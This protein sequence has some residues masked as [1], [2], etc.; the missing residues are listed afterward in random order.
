MSRDSDPEIDAHLRNVPLPSGMLDALRMIPL[1]EERCEEDEAIDQAL[2]GMPIPAGFLE[3]L[4]EIPHADRLDSDVADLPVPASLTKKLKRIPIESQLARKHLRWQLQAVAALLFVAFTTTLWTTVGAMVTAR[5]PVTAEAD[6][7]LVFV[8][9]GPL[10]MQV[11][12]TPVFQLADSNNLESELAGDT[13]T[14]FSADRALRES[15]LAVAEPAELAEFE[16]SS[17]IF[18]QVSQLFANRARVWDDVSLLRQGVLG[19]A[20]YIDD[21]LAEV[22]LP[23]WPVSRGIEPPIA[24]GYDRSFFLRNRVFPPIPPRASDELRTLEPPL[25]FAAERAW[26][27]SQDLKAARLVRPSQI[28]VEDF[29][30]A[31]DYRFPVPQAGLALRT[32]A[33]PSIASLTDRA[34]SPGPR[35]SLLLLGIQGANIPK[36]APSRHMI[37]AVDVSSSMHRQGRMQQVRSALDKFTSQMRDGDQLSIVA[38]RDVSEV[39]VERATASEAQSAV[40]MLDLPV[41]V[42][43]TNLASGLQ[44]SL[45][46]AMQAPG[47]ATATP[48]SA[49]SVVVITDGTPEW[50]HATV[51]QLH[52][53]AADAAQQ[54]IEMHVALVG[55]NARA[56]LAAERDSLGTLA[57]DKLSSLLAGEV[58]A[59]DSSRN[60]YALLTDTLAGGSAVLAS[61]ARLRIDFNPQVVSAYRLL[62]HGA[63]ALADVRPAEVS[64]EIR[65]GETAVVL[66]ELWLA[67]DS[68]QSSS[69]DVATAHLSWLHPATGQA[70]EVRQ[71]VSRLQIA[72]SWNEAS[73]PLQAAALAAGLAEQLRGTTQ[74]LA[75]LRNAAAGSNGTGNSAPGTPTTT[76]NGG[77]TTTPAQAPYV[78][79]AR[80]ARQSSSLLSD[81]TEFVE[82][83]LLLE[84]LAEKPPR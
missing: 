21:E 1:D 40:A 23:R 49:T 78:Q 33:G 66:V 80:L 9:D 67:V 8:Y 84:Q 16:V 64:A 39:L 3:S 17:S 32:A 24:R 68:G 48:P 73:A 5:F 72:P 59:I 36:T 2:R 30:A 12:Q 11:E 18:S 74:Q 44:Q 4:L 43:G 42:S 15:T 28:A 76:P 57:L 27:A 13:S 52:A 83:R 14:P 54:R 58:H 50:S 62:G 26:Q 29:L 20:D 60:L 75:T 41:V 37:V 6:P 56:Q 51:Q 55:N 22:S 82:L 71:R 47:D 79:L 35:S 46:L 53:L 45:L 25:W 31:M 10:Q 19:S 77:T 63:T 34:A 61:E 69:D 38:F 65:A 81:R 7:A 70:T